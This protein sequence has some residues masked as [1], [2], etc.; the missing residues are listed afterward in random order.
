MFPRPLAARGYT[1]TPFP[2]EDGT[3]SKTTQ[4]G[5]PERR[6]MLVRMPYD[7]HGRLREAAKRHH[8]S[9]NDIAV[10]AIEQFCQ[11]SESLGRTKH[12]PGV[13]Q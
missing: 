8:T 4:D 13:M 11:Q 3:V 10:R 9:A 2:D 1:P 12:N 7:L 6:N 5:T